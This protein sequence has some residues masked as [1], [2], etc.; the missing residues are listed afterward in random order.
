MAVTL[1]IKLSTYL[2]ELMCG[3]VRYY[4]VGGHLPITTYGTTMRKVE[5]N[6]K[7]SRVIL[8]RDRPK[9]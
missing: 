3:S 5:E 2:K 6:N 7:D 8:I 1:E 9:T 4:I